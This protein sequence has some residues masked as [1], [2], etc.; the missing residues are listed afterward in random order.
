MHN[1]TRVA[2]QVPCFSKWGIYACTRHHR[3]SRCVE[4]MAISDNSPWKSAGA[5]SELGESTSLKV[6]FPSLI[7]DKPYC[8]DWPEQGLQ[9]RKRE[10]ALTKRH[11]QLNSPHIIRWLAFD[12][13][14]PGARFAH[15]DAYLPAPNFI[16]ENP[17]TKHI[18]SAY[19]LNVPVQNSA[20]S[21][22]RPLHYLAAVQRGLLRRLGADRN[23][24]GL[25]SKNPLHADWRVY[26]H[27]RP[28]TLGELESWL[29]ERDLAVEFSVPEA[30]G[31]GRNCTVFDEV[32]NRCYREI[33]PFKRKGGTAEEWQLRC[34]TL[35]A[36]SNAQFVR[37]L[38]T[39][40]IR[41]IAKSIA[42]WTWRSFSEVSLS[43][44]QSRLGALGAL[45]RW[46]GH[47]SLETTRP[48]SAEGI[49]RATFYRKKR[50]A[51]VLPK[52]ANWQMISE[53]VEG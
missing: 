40:E 34:V 3:S 10:T 27:N 17:A 12:I 1:A 26:W 44:R 11:V 9:I 52:G 39:S 6:L 53:N 19:C 5:L 33:M 48:W 32:R 41:A 30:T 49:S 43:R 18:L 28:Y 23:Y 42:K 7:P 50:R 31:Y 25:L 37:P 38:H 13:D 21:R 35:A 22:T 51:L 2:A 36:A 45:R 20:T 46:E 4:T 15:E 47:T 24:V 16:A 8:A 29:F 14:R